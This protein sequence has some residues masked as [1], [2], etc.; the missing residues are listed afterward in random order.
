MVKAAVNIVTFN[1]AGDITRCL[2]SLQQQTFK[3]FEIHVFDN[4]S[5]DDTLKAVE[6]FDVAYVMRSPINTGFCKPH[7]D[8]VRRFPNDYRSYI[9][10]G[11]YHGFFCFLSA[12]IKLS[13][14]S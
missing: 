12:M 10:R 1:S 2:E 14:I 11:L 13:K 4:A 5:I 9:F 3:D 6:R 7:N 8:L